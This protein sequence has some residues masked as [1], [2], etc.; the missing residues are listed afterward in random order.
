M[1]KYKQERNYIE[2]RQDE[3]QAQIS[4]FFSNFNDLEKRVQVLN[5]VKNFL[6]QQP[7]VSNE[8]SKL[9]GNKIGTYENLEL[10]K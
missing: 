7:K 2:I 4:E 6:T 10:F 8:V 9:S 5:K 3:N 1:K